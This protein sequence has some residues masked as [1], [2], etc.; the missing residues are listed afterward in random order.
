MSNNLSDLEMILKVYEK[1]LSGTEDK[2]D[3]R[4]LELAVGVKLADMVKKKAEC[5]F[6]VTGDVYSGGENYN[7][8][9]EIFRKDGNH[10][11][12]MFS[13]K[14]SA[15]DTG[16]GYI[17][18]SV[19]QVLRLVRDTPQIMGIIL[20]ERA[21]NSGDTKERNFLIT[22]NMAAIALGI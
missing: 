15:A 13:D 16:K 22:R 20:T 8:Q 4:A 14:E 11:F 2:T 21:G 18:A 17:S 9:L 7:Y 5:F 1:A 6:A 19:E 12:L 10:Y 3:G